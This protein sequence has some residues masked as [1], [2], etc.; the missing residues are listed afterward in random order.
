M[1]TDCPNYAPIPRQVQRGTAEEIGSRMDQAA[2][3][4]PADREDEVSTVADKGL[5]ARERLSLKARA[6]RKMVLIWRLFILMLILIPTGIGGYVYWA[7]SSQQPKYTIDTR[8]CLYQDN[9][10][11]IKITGTRE[12]SYYQRELFGIQF[13]LK[14]QVEE[15]TTMNVS[16]EQQT[17]IGTTGK[18]MWYVIVPMAE[19][20]VQALKPA[21][22][23]TVIQPKRVFSFDY[24]SFCR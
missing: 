6:Y 7:L 9:E 21:D 22:L 16:S 13:K 24:A 3:D 15:K 11:G 12:Y 19:P 20:G 5:A 18:S 23:I 4:V 2:A 10:R 1:T 8:S 14:D 17:I